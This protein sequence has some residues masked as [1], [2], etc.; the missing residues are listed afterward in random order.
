[1]ARASVNWSDADMALA[2]AAAG[3][4]GLTFNKWLARAARET[5][6]MEAALVK[7]AGAE[8]VRSVGAEPFTLSTSSAAAELLYRVPERAFR[9]DPRPVSAKKGRSGR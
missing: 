1:M 8:P 9:P 5:A 3:A 6:A 2:R 4:A 7:Q